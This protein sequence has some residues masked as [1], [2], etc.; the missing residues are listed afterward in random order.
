MNGRKVVEEDIQGLEHQELG[1]KERVITPFLAYVRRITFGKMSKSKMESLEKKLQAAGHPFRLTAVD[2]KLIQLS[3]SVIVFIL[4]FFLFG[5]NTEE[6]FKVIMMSTIFSIFVYAY[7]N[8]YLTAKKKARIK[9][10]EKSMSDFF[11]MITVSIEAGMGLDG[12][13]KKVCKQMHSPLSTEFLYALEDM[14]LGKTRRQA[15]IE[16][17]E[18]VPSEFFRS[19]MNSIIQADQLG[20][21][22]T[23]VLQAQTQRIRENQRQVAKEQAMKAP[24]KMLIPMVVFIF[25]TLFIV[26]LGPVVVNLVTKWL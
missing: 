18:R 16:L 25:P 14:K 19:I 23:K 3:L 9:V 13:L 5:S 4:S 20:I 15:F 22:M 6:T 1:F 7:F 26:L 10:I 11:D 8:F 12:A 17:R 24:V 21:G 2:F